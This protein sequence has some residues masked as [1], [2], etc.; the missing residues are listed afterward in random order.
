MHILC[1][2]RLRTRCPS[3]PEEA[4]SSRPPCQRHTPPS[5]VASRKLPA[6]PR[7]ALS[8]FLVTA[9]LALSVAV[10]ATAEV[11]LPGWEARLPPFLGEGR[12]FP[13]GRAGA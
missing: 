2:P 13:P 8:C 6:S 12:H 1:R 7:G 10:L 9:G 3:V 4:L 5:G 11:L